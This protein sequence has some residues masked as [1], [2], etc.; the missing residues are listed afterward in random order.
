MGCRS[1][2][3]RLKEDFVC[4]FQIQIL[5]QLSRGVGHVEGLLNVCE[6][7]YFYDAIIGM[8]CSSIG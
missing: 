2:G 6:E 7:C 1:S 4:L 5:W 8:V 3:C